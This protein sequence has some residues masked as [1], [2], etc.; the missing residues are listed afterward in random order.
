VIAALIVLIVLAGIA[1]SYVNER[2]RARKPNYRYIAWLEAQRKLP[3]ATFEQRHSWR[4]RSLQEV[5]P[6]RLG[7]VMEVLACPQCTFNAVELEEGE[8]VPCY[9]HERLVAN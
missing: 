3:R 8:F 5:R 9:A 7:V 4:V 1:A 2:R 6:A